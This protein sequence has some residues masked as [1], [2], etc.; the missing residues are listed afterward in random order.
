M[1]EEVDVLHAFDD[2]ECTAKHN[3]RENLREASDMVQRAVDDEHQLMAEALT[4]N[5]VL[6]IGNNRAVADHYT[7]GAACGA[8][9]IE[10]VGYA[11][12]NVVGREL[13]AQFIE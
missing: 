4:G 10:H 5:Q 3:H 1:E 13:F 2:V 8:G 6:G 9:R 12:R 7:L 11:F